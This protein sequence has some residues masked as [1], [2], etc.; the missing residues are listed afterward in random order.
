MP[1]PD[2]HKE[3]I[4]AM[5]ENFD[6]G[7]AVA[8]LEEIAN[9]VADSQTP[10]DEIDKYINRSAELVKSCREYLR[11]AHEKF[12]RLEQILNGDAE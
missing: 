3:E 5:E 9:K 12:Y 8:E 1:C 2:F 4:N 11:T 6:Y 7:K 10:F